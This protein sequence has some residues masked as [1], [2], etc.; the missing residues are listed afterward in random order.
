MYNFIP[1]ILK[2][3]IIAIATYFETGAAD[4]NRV[5]K[6]VKNNENVYVRKT[7]NGRYGKYYYS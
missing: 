6:T 5:R 2:L 1:R 4:H 3:V 7:L